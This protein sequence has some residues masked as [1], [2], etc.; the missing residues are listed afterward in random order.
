MMLN[1]PHQSECL[2]LV[3]ALYG[4]M[5]HP[6]RFAR[7]RAACER[8]LCRQVASDTPA[9]QFLR[10]QVSHA[11][12]ARSLSARAGAEVPSS[13]AVVTLDDQGRVLAAG[14][15][16]W[17]LL[18]SGGSGDDPLRVP[19]ALRAFVEDARRGGPVP[20]AV[21][22]PLDDGSTELAGVVLGVD[23]VRHAVGSMRVLTLLLCDVGEA[24]A[25]AP[26]RGPA[27]IRPF[28]RP[29]AA[30]RPPAPGV[31]LAADRPA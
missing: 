13:C 19:R 5:S 4:A 25:E 20:R 10:M 2:S 3:A 27:Q 18:G 16:A 14:A 11:A 9:A 12:E 17:T 1:D 23:Q 15:E 7:Q 26:G 31:A 22:V 30:C 28:P 6:D 24:P 21:R 29:A 8:W